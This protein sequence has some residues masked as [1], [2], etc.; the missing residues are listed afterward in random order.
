MK[1]FK[2]TVRKIGNSLG[3][4]LNSGAAEFLDA[5]EGAT[6]HLTKSSDGMRITPFDPTF[7]EKL[8]KA[9]SIMDRYKNTLKE[10]A[11]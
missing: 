1:S 3:I 4:I 8:S 9:S 5:K 7:E 2:I 6:Y 11:K 10:L